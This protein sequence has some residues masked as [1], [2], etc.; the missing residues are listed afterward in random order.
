MTNAQRDELLISLVTRMDALNNK[1]DNLNVS[2]NKKID[3]VNVSLNKKI[4]DVNDSLNKKIDDVNASLNKKIDDVKDELTGIIEINI[5]AAVEVIQ[6]SKEFRG[7][8]IERVQRLESQ[9]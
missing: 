5:N 6:E 8:I 4:D 1:M 9:I 7:Y 3:D 2:L